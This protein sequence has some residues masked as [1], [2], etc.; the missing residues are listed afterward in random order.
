MNIEKHDKLSSDLKQKSAEIST[1]AGEIWREHYTAIIGAGQVEYMLE[2]F[3]TAQQIY[4]D[5]KE[6]NYVYFSANCPK[7]KTMTGYCAVQPRDGHLFLSKIY[8]R[9]SERGK[10][11]AHSF[12]EKVREFDYN[13]IRLTV[14]KHNSGAIAVYKKEGFEIIDEVNVNIG[15]GYFMDDYVMEIR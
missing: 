8:V 12:L 10:G 7:T 11:I 14:N 15:G 1:L 6:N 2:R 4:I 5:I 9:K 3:Q 13:I